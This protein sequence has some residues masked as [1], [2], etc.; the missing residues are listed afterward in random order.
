METCQMFVNKW[1]L[2]L[3]LASALFTVYLLSQPRWATVGQEMG[4]GFTREKIIYWCKLGQTSSDSEV[5]RYKIV[6]KKRDWVDSGC[7]GV[8]GGKFEFRS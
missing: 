6:F 2:G 1:M 5:R 7:D 3:C 8:L 4:A